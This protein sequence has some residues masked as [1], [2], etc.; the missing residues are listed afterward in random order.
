[1]QTTVQVGAAAPP[2][3][4]ARGDERIRQNCRHLLARMRY[5]RAHNRTRGLPAGRIDLPADEAAARYAAEAA[6]LIQRGEPRAK[7]LSAS[8]AGADEMGQI[9]FE[10]VMQID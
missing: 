2:N 10:V 4:S 6:A 3:W 7:I 1:M 5:E 8:R 9:I